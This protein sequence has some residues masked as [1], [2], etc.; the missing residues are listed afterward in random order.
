MAATLGHLSCVSRVCMGKDSG[1]RQRAVLVGGIHSFAEEQAV[2]SM[3]LQHDEF[4]NTDGSNAAHAACGPLYMGQ[5][6]LALP[7]QQARGTRRSELRTMTHCAE[8][9]CRFT[10][11]TSLK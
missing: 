8:G 6:C 9:Y 4:V 2:V 3:A 10:P 7:A 1:E 11:W 5:P